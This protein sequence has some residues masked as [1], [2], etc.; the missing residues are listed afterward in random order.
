MIIEWRED[1]SLSDKEVEIIEYLDKA[2]NSMYTWYAN[3][4]GDKHPFTQYEAIGLV[5]NGFLTEGSDY[6]FGDRY[7][8]LTYKGNKL[9]DLIATYKKLRG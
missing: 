1:L 2:E 5:K 3:D 4:H 6:N 9:A 8:F 7:V